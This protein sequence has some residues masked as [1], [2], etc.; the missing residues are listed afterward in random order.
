MALIPLSVGNSSGW[1]PGPAPTFHLGYRRWLDGLRGVAI[2]MVLAF[3]LLLLPG[4]SLGVDVF[5]VLS[6]FLITSLLAEEWERRGALSLRHF[7]LR[8]GL[9]LLPALFTLLLIC[10]VYSLF[11][12]SMEATAVRKEMVVA[13]GYVA[14]WPSLHQ[15]G[16]SLLGHT[17]SLS[18][19]EQFYLLWPVLLLGM[20]R[21]RL[22]RRQVL[23]LVAAGIVLSA[24]LRVGLYRGL[25]ATTPNRTQT[26]L[27]LYMGLDTRADALLMG[28]LAGLLAAW[29][30]L[31]K[32]QRFVSL[33][34]LLSVGSCGV[35]GYLAW[36]RCLDHSQ[37]YHGLFTVVALMVAVII[38]RLLSAPSR[39]G[40][41]LLES[42]PLVGLGRISYGMYLYHIPVIHWLRPAGIGW[43]APGNTLLM[44]A[45]TLVAALVSYS[46][47]ERP[48]LRLKE[49]FSSHGTRVPNHRTDQASRTGSQREAA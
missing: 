24:L 41:L 12:P 14:N 47:I 45:G 34:G 27:R 21:W 8:R 20:L 16:M 22:S 29:N 10:G 25:L 38:V 19:E 7:Y 44:A 9:R 17:W 4:G 32:S 28:A 3:H 6:G 2:L 15:T 42:A 46:L 23:W 11:L 1:P 49:R 18:L 13:A 43:H 31:P 26:L 40:A 39:A 33:M 36:Y 5:F 37:Y 35:L 30:L 48:C